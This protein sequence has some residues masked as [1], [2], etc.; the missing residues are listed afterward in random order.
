MVTITTTKDDATYPLETAPVL[1][2]ARNY[3][4]H[5][6]HRNSAKHIGK[7]IFDQLLLLSHLLNGQVASVSVINK[8]GSSIGAFKLVRISGFDTTAGKLK[9]VLADKDSQTTLAQFVTRAAI[10]NDASGVVYRAAAG[11]SQNT[12][13]LAVGDT[14]YLGD[15]GAWSATAGRQK[16]GVVKTVHATTGTIEFYV[17]DPVIRFRIEDLLNVDLAGVLDGYTLSWNAAQ[18]KFVVAANATTDEKVKGSSG[19]ATAGYLDAK[20]DNSTIEVS[21]NALR[22]KASGILNSHIGAAAAIAWSKISKSGAVAGDVG[23]EY[24][25]SH[26]SH[27]GA[28]SAADN[29]DHNNDGASGDI[30]GTLPAAVVGVRV[31]ATILAGHK[32]TLNRAGSD[33]IY[34]ND[35][36][37]TNTN[38]FAN[39]V[40]KTIE[41][42]CKKTGVWIINFMNG[43]W[44]AA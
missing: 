41:L 9:I 16:V 4:T 5:V 28:F 17:D 7:V 23:A 29:T 25:F 15:D 30:V 40:G 1:Q 34:G 24:P 6:G 44:T 32:I 19:D 2:E 39:T 12:S 36:S 14:V 21:S 10:A 18:S 33:V 27:T 31:R 13:G 26:S 20:V 35:G 37:T 11:T 43:A 3:P 22:V 8:T 42:E 38:V